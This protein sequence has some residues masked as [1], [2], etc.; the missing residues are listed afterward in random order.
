MY[1]T[2]S[3][4]TLSHAHRSALRVFFNNQKVSRV[5]RPYAIKV[6]K[7][8]YTSQHQKIREV[9]HYNTQEAMVALYFSNTKQRLLLEA[10]PILERDLG[11]F[12]SER[13]VK[14]S[15][16]SEQGRVVAPLPTWN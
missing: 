12:S 2:L 16:K 14:L 15:V 13:D 7:S 5:R 4:T 11:W 9:V 10:L 1:F 3:Q 6:E 8:H